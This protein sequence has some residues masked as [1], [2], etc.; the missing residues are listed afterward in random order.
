[1]PANSIGVIRADNVYKSQKT[2]STSDVVV[3]LPTS[4]KRNH[5]ATIE[6]TRFIASVIIVGFSIWSFA[7]PTQAVESVTH[8]DVDSLDGVVEL[9]PSLLESFTMLFPTL[10]ETSTDIPSNISFFDSLIAIFVRLYATIVVVATT[11]ILG[12]QTLSRF[13]AVVYCLISIGLASYIVEQ[14]RFDV[15]KEWF[16]FVVLFPS[17]MIPT[18]ACS[19]ELYFS[20]KEMK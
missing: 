17:C 18:I 20:L 7:E 2:S 19:I 5:R 16:C 1:M 3:A 13:V 8:I 4:V 14:D 9:I 15:L 11:G 10:N 6:V 12:R